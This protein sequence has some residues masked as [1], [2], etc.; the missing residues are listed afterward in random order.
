L[1]APRGIVGIFNALPDKASGEKSAMKL[2]DAACKNAKPANKPIRML[3]GGGLYLEVAPK[4]SKLW[5]MA[6]R[7]GGKQKT[8]AFGP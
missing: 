4:G 2:T 7:F 6:Y 5:R 3:D 8:L 1:E